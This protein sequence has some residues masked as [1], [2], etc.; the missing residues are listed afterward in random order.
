MRGNP[1]ADNELAVGFPRPL[2]WAYLV[3]ILVFP[4]PRKEKKKKKK[5][6]K[7]KSNWLYVDNFWFFYTNLSY[8][9]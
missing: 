2:F 8:I 4:S 9:S 5:K 3:K 1:S 7:V 6:K